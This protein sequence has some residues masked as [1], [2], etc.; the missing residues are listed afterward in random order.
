[1]AFGT[2]AVACV[3]NPTETCQGVVTNQLASL[4]LAPLANQFRLPVAS[5][6][7]EV[8]SFPLDQLQF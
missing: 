3:L 1:M 7:I 4:P 6:V 2:Q 5:L 8:A